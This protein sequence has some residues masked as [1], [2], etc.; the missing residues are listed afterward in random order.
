[1]K[2]LIFSVLLFVSIFGIKAQ[3][4]E[5]NRLD[6]EGNKLNSDL[7]TATTDTIK[8]KIFGAQASKYFYTNRTLAMYY[9]EEALKIAERIK[10]KKRIFKLNHSIAILYQDL[11]YDK[12]DKGET[13]KAKEYQLKGLEV[14]MKNEDTYMTIAIC[15]NLGNIYNI[16]GDLTKALDYDLKALRLSENLGDQKQLAITNSNLGIL[17]LEMKDSIK[18]L[19][20]FNNALNIFIKMKDSVAMAIMCDDI[21]E[22]YSITQEID[23][24]FE[25]ARKAFDIRKKIRDTLYISYSYSN[26][27]AAYIRK[28]RYATAIEFYLKALEL[29]TKMESKQFIADD[30]L[31]MAVTYKFSK[32]YNKAIEVL[33]KGFA[34]VKAVDDKKTELFSYGLYSEIYELEGNFKKALEYNKLKSTLNDSIYN[35]DKNK[36][37]AELQTQYETEEK[38]K[39]IDHLT[40]QTKI[41]QL[42][43]SRNQ[44][45]ILGLGSLALLIIA[46]AF[47]F[48]RQR[49]L[50]ANQ[51]KMEVEQKLFRSQMNPHFIFNSL[52]AIQNYVYK[53]QPAEVAKYISSFAKLMRMIL[54]NYRNEFVTI[55]KE[56]DTLKYYLELQ[57]LRFQDKFDFSIEVD[58]KIDI[59][60]VSIPP[61]LS[62]PF[63]EN[64]IEHGIMN[65][66]DGKG[67]ITLKFIQQDKMIQLIIED[68]G[69]G[70]ENANKMKTQQGS[71]HTSLAT[72]ITQERLIILNK[73][74]KRKF[75]LEIKDKKNDESGSEGTLVI[76]TM[77]E[78]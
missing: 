11:G 19:V 42:E 73:K 9:F 17:Y 69:I 32:E 15:N 38:E 71:K 13:S 40:Q 58:P 20:Y 21:A 66:Q 4:I 31:G 49:K 74:S 48:S 60:S 47:L 72:T 62:Q 2:T 8:I 33:D 1:M 10:D 55:E 24:Q 26:M 56:I 23:K 57:Q 75:S 6:P 50:K 12:S 77:P 67:I 51:T 14:A 36:K 78:A 41:Q 76:I 44:Y 64:S 61:M 43:I 18:S 35:K 30:Y 45:L 68:N 34:I 53:H 29:H 22:V 25:Y 16:S 63:I 7:K 65:K 37:I 27:A 52:I 70:M 3:N 28:K 54:E 59:E 39:E 46:F 5:I